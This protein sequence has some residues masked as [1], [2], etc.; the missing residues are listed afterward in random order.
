MI[1]IELEH[2][3]V[4][5]RYIN[6]R[7]HPPRNFVAVQSYFPRHVVCSSIKLTRIVDLKHKPTNIYQPKVLQYPGAFWL[8]AV[9]NLMSSAVKP[10]LNQTIMLGNF[11]YQENLT[12][13]AHS[14]QRG[15]MILEK[16][17]MFQDENSIWNCWFQLLI[18]TAQRALWFR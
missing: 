15:F 5:K 10:C 1:S 13:S 6:T 14:H 18:S 2:H 7:K 11:G 17:E 16:L 9:Q 4:L 8:R 3:G 12:H